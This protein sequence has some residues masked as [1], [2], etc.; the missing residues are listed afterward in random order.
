MILKFE[1]NKASRVVI[2]RSEETDLFTAF[3]HAVQQLDMPTD[4]EKL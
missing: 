4:S 1:E 3:N 2:S